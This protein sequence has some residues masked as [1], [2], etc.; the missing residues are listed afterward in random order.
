MKS[1]LKKTM[2]LFV[3]VSS[4]AFAQQETKLSTIW[5]TIEKEEAV[6]FWEGGT[7]LSLI[8]I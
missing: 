5:L 7:L 4:C 2:S 3:V 8:H 1:I 6:P